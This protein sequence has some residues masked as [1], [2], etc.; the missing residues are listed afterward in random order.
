MSSDVNLNQKMVKL[1]TIMT[2]IST[3]YWLTIFLFIL[4]FP[5]IVLFVYEIMFLIALNDVKKL[6]NDDDISSA[7]TLMVVA[8]ILNILVVGALVSWILQLIAFGKLEDWANREAAKRNS[9]AMRTAADG[10]HNVFLG[11]IL[12]LIIVG[13]FIIPGG[14]KK[15]GNA[16]IQEYSRT[17]STGQYNNVSQAAPSYKPSQPTP[18]QGSAPKFCPACGAPIEDPGQKFCRKC[19]NSLR[20]Q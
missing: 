2:K 7:F 6:T 10:F 9:E 5:P 18:Q 15:A 20:G 13:I 14:F 19:G 3:W 1:G 12:T 16:L 11:S 4:I 17:Q 8:V